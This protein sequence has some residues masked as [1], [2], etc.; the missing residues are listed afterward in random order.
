MHSILGFVM[1][2]WDDGKDKRENKER[3]DGGVSVGN[4]K[5]APGFAVG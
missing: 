5:D 3:G 1:I 2:H 4:N